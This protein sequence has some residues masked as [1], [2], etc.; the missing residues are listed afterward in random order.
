MTIF[1]IYC[2]N[3]VLY[4]GTLAKY[5]YTIWVKDI[6][7]KVCFMDEGSF[8]L[9]WYLFRKSDKHLKYSG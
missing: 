3:S 2:V 9:L 8:V 4:S 6:V 7:V 1:C 5:R